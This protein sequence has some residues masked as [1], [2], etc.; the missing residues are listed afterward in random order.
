MAEPF[1]ALIPFVTTGNEEWLKQAL[2][3][4]PKGTPYMVLRNDGELAEA[5]NQGLREAETDL[6]FRLDADDMVGPGCLEF[7]SEMMWDCDVAYP[8]LVLTDENL[9]VT[10]RI[11]APHFSEGRLRLWNNVPGAAMFRRKKALEVGGYRDLSMVED[12]DLWIRMLNHG[13]RFK[14]VREAEYIYRRSAGTRNTTVETPEFFDSIRDND[15]T[16]EATWYHQEVAATSYYRCQLPAR[17]LGQSVANPELVERDGEVEFPYHRGDSIWQF[18]GDHTS[19]LLMVNLQ[20]KGHLAIVEVDDNYLGARRYMKAWSKGQDSHASLET[21]RKIVEKIADGVITS[22][23]HLA[24]QYARVNPNVFVCPNQVDPSDW[25]APEKPDDDVFR[26]GWFGSLSHKDD[27]P[28]VTRA[29][30]WASKQEGVEVECM[31]VGASRVIDG[32]ESWHRNW[33]QFRYRHF[34]WSN[35]MGVYRKLMSRLDVGLAPVKE[36]PWS[37]CRSD[38]KALE[39]GMA[40]VCPIL[41]DSIPYSTFDGPCIRATSAR[42]FFQEVKYLVAHKDEAKQIAAEARAHILAERTIEKN[43][44]RWE[45]CLAQLRSNQ[46]ILVG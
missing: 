9:N 23:P 36:N 21:H 29:L 26:I 16:Y 10:G 44:W 33:W 42:D 12:W 8:T 38:L 25:D 11:K 32:N 6:V 39:Y 4:L 1:T 24:K 13:S 19:A 31:G 41:S 2:G 27:A 14:P 15:H 43:L 46:R 5:L 3:S 40:G 37:A 22:T 35:D 30:E 20:S 17:F 28:L 34:P 45:E 18:P 7:L